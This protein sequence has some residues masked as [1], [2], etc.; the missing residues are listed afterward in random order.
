MADSKEPKRKKVVPRWFECE[1]GP[2]HVAAAKALMIGEARADQQIEFMKWL[3]NSACQYNE[4]AWEA[5]SERA[6]S[7]E[8]GRRY[9]GVQIVKL[10]QIVIK[11]KENV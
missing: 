3:V 8:A 6:S 10:T 5:E 1:Y 4:V 7:F 11:E 2:V 9:V